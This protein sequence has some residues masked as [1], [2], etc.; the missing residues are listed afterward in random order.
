MAVTKWLY[1]PD[2]KKYLNPKWKAKPAKP[3]S[4]GSSGSS[5]DSGSSGYSS[6]SS[7]SSGSGGSSAPA[8]PKLPPGAITEAQKAVIERN[9][10]RAY[11]NLF[12]PGSKRSVPDALMAY[13]KKWGFDDPTSIIRWMQD[14]KFKLWE[15]TTTAIAR[16]KEAMSALDLI[17]GENNKLKAAYV[18]TYIW[19]D[20]KTMDWNTFL[21]KKVVG[22][23]AFVK[24]YPG[25]KA[26]RNKQSNMDNATAITAFGELRNSM[27][28]WYQDAMGDPSAKMSNATFNDAMSQNIQA[29]KNFETYVRTSVPAY[30]GSSEAAK[31][32]AQE[33]DDLWTSLFGEDAA[34]D[35][36]MKT[37]FTRTTEAATIGDF[38]NDVIRVSDQFKQ[39]EPEFEGW[40]SA[41]T[42]LTDA[43]TA[44][45]DPSKFFEDRQELRDKYDILTEG[46]GKTND[47][48]IREAM[49]NMWSVERL[50]IEFKAKDPNYA[51]TEDYTIKAEALQTYWWG[52]FGA[53]SV[54]SQAMTDE[55]TRGN[56]SDVTSMF[57]SIKKTAE[58]QTQYGNWAEF[59][60]AQ[61]YAGNNTK[62]MRDPAM[63]K[64]Y[65]D[66][67]NQAFAAVGM[68]APPEF[69]K[70]MFASGVDPNTLESNLTDY[71]QTK[72]SYNTWT[73]EPADLATASGIGNA[74]EGGDLRL[75]MKQALEAHKA[76]AAS[77]F[78][79]AEETKKSGFSTSNI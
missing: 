32:K 48:L 11:N 49:R 60:S 26:W 63:Y 36:K 18:K 5:G 15:K 66:T 25:F 72:N 28:S 78:G 61:D 24:E 20:P 12:P 8:K 57:D 39:A 38:F 47:A 45:V 74:A 1:T 44:H 62:I 65:R 10:K 79:T 41:S 42:G 31:S 76:Y 29:Q 59:Q 23:K 53:D 34:P 16:G 52:I 67:F 33:F 21:D 55:Y 17:F 9:I 4:T 6:G 73:G 70:R 50:E 64:Q 7:G 40:A 75:R 51:G 22:S 35:E 46:K 77:K 71:V 37:A 54:P 3:A 68:P 14:T 30:S 56:S 2:G 69:E 19:G 58:F 43:S 13:A 27:N